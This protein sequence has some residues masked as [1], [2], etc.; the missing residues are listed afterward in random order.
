MNQQQELFYGRRHFAV[1]FGRQIDFVQ[2]AESFGISAFSMS[3]PDAEAQLETALREP[4]P[5]LIHVSTKLG[6]IV[7][8]MVPPGGSNSEMI[9]EKPTDPLS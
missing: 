2:L 5:R 3:A 8:P 6:E 1:H 9:T 7:F 4:G